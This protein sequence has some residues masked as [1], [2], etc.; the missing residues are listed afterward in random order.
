MLRLVHTIQKLAS[1]RI[2]LQISAWKLGVVPNV[3]R[4]NF[5][6]NS[7]SDQYLAGVNERLGQTV[8]FEQSLF[9]SQSTVSIFF[10]PFYLLQCLQYL[11]KRGNKFSRS[12]HFR[13]NCKNVNFF[14]LN[15][16][17]LKIIVPFL[18]NTKLFNAPL[19]FIALE[20]L[21]QFIATLLNG[22]FFFVS[23]KVITLLQL[24]H[25]HFALLMLNYWGSFSPNNC[26]FIQNPLIDR[27]VGR[28]SIGRW[29][30]QPGTQP[31]MTPLYWNTTH[32][33]RE[34]NWSL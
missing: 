31:A 11:F 23:A 16:T 26:V 18:F 8:R 29:N 2:L 21:T 25:C 4:K 19:S 28:V 14:Q 20:N 30:S 12:C 13:F 24:L 17:D 1:C 22:H 33:E 6:K 34:T 15:L 3:K 9:R 10:S 27:I 32:K 7:A 5:G